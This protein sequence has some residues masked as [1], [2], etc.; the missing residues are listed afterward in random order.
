MKQF[1][2]LFHRNTAAG[3]PYPDAQCIPLAPL[4]DHLDASAILV[5][6]DRIGQQVQKDLLQAN[7][8]AE[9]TETIEVVFC[10]HDIDIA[11]TR[12]RCHPV[13]AVTQYLA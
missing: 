7:R 2:E 8:I 13:H 12:E 3:I 11:L 6:L 9:H 10:K 1:L 4:E 5:V